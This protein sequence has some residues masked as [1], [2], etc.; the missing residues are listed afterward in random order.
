MIE[1]ALRLPRDAFVLDVQLSLPSRGVSALF[2]PSGCGKT[3]LLRALAGLERAD[4]F[5]RASPM[6][7]AF[8]A[9]LSWKPKL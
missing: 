5:S 2:G 8:P 4:G 3:T 9:N 6:V 7:V 1:L